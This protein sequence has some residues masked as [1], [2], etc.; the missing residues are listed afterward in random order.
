LEG[1]TWRAERGVTKNNVNE[2]EVLN[3][4]GMMKR[5]AMNASTHQRTGNNG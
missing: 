2:N 1:K 4:S 3:R 5:Y